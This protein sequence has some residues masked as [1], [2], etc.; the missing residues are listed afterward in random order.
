[1]NS[2]LTQQQQNYAS[3]MES[4]GIPTTEAALKN[5]FDQMATAEGLVFKNENDRGAWWRWL[6]NIAVDPVLW[7]IRFVITQVIPN[8]FVKT[9]SGQYLDVLGWG[10]DLERYTANKA[11]GLIKFVRA[12]SGSNLTIPVNTW[13]RTTS[14]NGAVYRVKAIEEGV[15]A[16]DDLYIWVKVEAEKTG[17]AYNLA[18]DYYII[19]EEPISGITSV[20]N[21]FDWLTLPGRDLEDDDSFRSR[22]RGQ[23]ASVSDFHVTSVYKTMIANNIGIAHDRIFIDYTLA[24][25]GPGSAN[26][27]VLF[28]LETPAQSYLDNVNSYIRDEGNHGFGDDMLVLAVPESLHD[29]SLK[30]WLPVNVQGDQA[31][32][33]FENIEQMI[34][35]AFRENNNFD[36]I[37]TQP[38]ARFSK[39]RLAGSILKKYTNVVS[40]EFDGGDIVSKQDIPKLSSLTITRDDIS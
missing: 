31:A 14:I 28:D 26:A 24:P 35:S 17:L 38:F 1:M 36:V 20:T 6:K 22:F 33:L 7:M 19:L 39:A 25:R 37:Q 13:I 8:Q 30:V 23:F 10:Y 9:A 32:A 21:E 15:F 40:V 4:A 18:D 3:S 27:Y 34:R 11:Q 2:E 29:V 12:S 16:T 5:K